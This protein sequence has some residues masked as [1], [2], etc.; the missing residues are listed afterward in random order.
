M[1]PSI[2]SSITMHQSIYSSITL[3]QS[4]YSSITMHP[5][6]YSSITMHQSIIPFV[7]PII[8]SFEQR[9]D[10]SLLFIEWKSCL[11][12][13]NSR[14]MRENIMENMTC[15]KIHE[16]YKSNDDDDEDDDGNHQCCVYLCASFIFSISIITQ[17][18]NNYCNSDDYD[19]DEYIRK[20]M[21]KIIIII[22]AHQIDTKIYCH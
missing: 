17:N 18:N 22:E 19:N 10:D 5:F 16:S 20:S 9:L 4:I 11:D 21:I 12:T 2:Y 6:I 8:D 7:D 3:H 15:N 1:H 13:I 14:D